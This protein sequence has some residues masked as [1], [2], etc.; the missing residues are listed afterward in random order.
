MR[1]R[2]AP[3]KQ[4]RIHLAGVE[5]TNH[6]RDHVSA[7][8]TGVRTRQKRS[9]DREARDKQ[10]EAE[11]GW[12][13]PRLARR[14]HRAR[15]RWGR[16]DCGTEQRKRSQSRG[17]GESPGGKRDEPSTSARLEQT[18]GQA[19][20]AGP[21]GEETGPSLGPF[22]ACPGPERRVTGLLE[23]IAR[24]VSFLRPRRRAWSST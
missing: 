12:E 23:R 11:G 19:G 21:A 14:T 20:K 24:H 8:Q 7:T 17:S 13:K 3:L 18:D 15:R 10:Q 22:L 5:R 1:S 9:Q 2:L 6:P 16:G 4:L